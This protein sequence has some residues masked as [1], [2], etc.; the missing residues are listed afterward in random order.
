MFEKKKTEYNP[1]NADINKAYI[2][3]RI[4]VSIIKPRTGTG[5]WNTK[6]PS[7]LIV[8]IRFVFLQESKS[9]RLKYYWFIFDIFVLV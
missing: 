3:F 1:V 5:G 4:A 9:C 6:A 7:A 8:L 2:R